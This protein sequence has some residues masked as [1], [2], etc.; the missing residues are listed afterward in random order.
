MKITV[1]YS[2]QRVGNKLYREFCATR[3]Y[4]YTRIDF[5]NLSLSQ[6]LSFNIYLENQAIY[7]IVISIFIYLC[8]TYIINYNLYCPLNYR[9][10]VISF[11]RFLRLVEIVCSKQIILF[12]VTYRVCKY[13]PDTTTL[14]FLQHI[15]I[16]SNMQTNLSQCC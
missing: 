3:T 4:L 8:T 13:V 15:G 5:E 2:T 14:L 16:V 7:G 1:I 10:A 11:L 9:A 12:H 6:Y